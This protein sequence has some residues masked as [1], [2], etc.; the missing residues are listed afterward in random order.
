MTDAFYV[1]KLTDRKIE[2]RFTPHSNKKQFLELDNVKVSRKLRNHS[3]KFMEFGG[4]ENSLS[5]VEKGKKRFRYEVCI[6]E[7]TEV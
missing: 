5:D 3:G 1:L 7:N 2:E 6:R 4:S